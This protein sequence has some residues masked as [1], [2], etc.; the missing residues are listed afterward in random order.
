LTALGLPVELFTPTLKTNA[1]EWP[2]LVRRLTDRTLILPQH[3][4]L[5][6]ELLNLA[7][8]V[9]ATGVRVTDKGKVH[10]DH[11]VA[12][13]GV[14]AALQ[15]W[16]RGEGIDPAALEQLTE[17]DHRLQRAFAAHMGIPGIAMHPD[18]VGDD[19][20]GAV[21]PDREMRWYSIERSGARRYLW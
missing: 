20:S 12:V 13:R 9:T 16:V 14:V 8:E 19:E 6:E 7:Y 4:R 15:P 18:F 11:A 21:D 2:V 17:E 1:E 3:G 10:Q 5:R